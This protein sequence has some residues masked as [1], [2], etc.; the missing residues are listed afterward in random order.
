M[1]AE[2]YL[3][4]YEHL[5]RQAERLTD[6]IKKL[7]EVVYAG[8]GAIRYDQ[9]RVIFSPGN[10]LTGVIDRK[11]MLEHV[12]SDT[13][14]E[15]IR[16]KQDLEEIFSHLVHRDHAIAELTWLDFEG[17]VYI[18]QKLHINRSTVFRRQKAIVRYV[19]E[20]LDQEPQS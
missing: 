4:T 12:L 5:Y 11:V 15:M 19:Q 17:S 6:E 9:D 10:G 20:I 1:K 8:K 7:E 14:D 16:L 13:I 3:Q 2:T 18:S